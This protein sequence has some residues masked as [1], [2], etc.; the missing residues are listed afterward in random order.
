MSESAE[1]LRNRPT[2]PGA[3]LRVLV[4]D[5]TADIRF[6]V[7]LTLERDGRFEV[8]GE[9]DDGA[10]AIVAAARLRPD[11][12]LL[13]LAMPVMDGLEAL[14]QI[15]AESAGSKIVVLSGFNAREM[16]ADALARGASSYLEKGGIADLLVPHILHHFP[17]RGDAPPVVAQ[18]A[19]GDR[20][21]LIEPAGGQPAA[22]QAEL[23]QDLAGEWVSVL[24]HE[25]N[26]PV[27]VLQGFALLLQQATDSMSQDAIKESAAAISRAAKHLGALVEAFSDL[28][29]IEINS[30]DLVLETA[31]V[32]ELVRETITDMAEVT[33]THPVILEVVDG[34]H[35]WIDPP[36]VR[37]VLI[38]LLANAAK[39]S[40]DATRI[41]VRMA[42]DNDHATIS[43]RDHGPGI[44]VDRLS[45]LFR[46]FSRLDPT[47]EGTGV[48]LFLSRGIARAHG[49]DLILAESSAPGCRFVLRLPLLRAVDAPAGSDGP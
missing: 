38:N 17:D 2:S 1:A 46:K 9:A 39:F 45:E 3:R 40:P 30:L 42:V 35:A 36:R 18:P 44:P 24:A 29:K 47:I 32:S 10:E 15:R 43:V 33:R 12:V 31:D 22:L 41:E 49:G 5:D 7:R 14:P 27:T 37:Q 21:A 25:L 4:V 11:V 6:L 26:N 23:A 13:D 16:S 48:G 19:A 8:V 20:L 28:R 34:V